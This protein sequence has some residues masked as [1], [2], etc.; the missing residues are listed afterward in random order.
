MLSYS[1]L[2]LNQIPW[3]FSFVDMLAL[4]VVSHMGLVV[5]IRSLPPLLIE[6]C[7]SFVVD[8]SIVNIV[9]MLNF[10]NVVQTKTP[11]PLRSTNLVIVLFRK[12]LKF[13]K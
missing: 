8:A 2:L 12:G 10:R 6:I 1:E 7:S 13:E 4:L 9:M 3:L 5:K 11:L